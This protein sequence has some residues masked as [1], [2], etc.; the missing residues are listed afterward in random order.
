MVVIICGAMASDVAP[1]V[2]TSNCL[3]LRTVR[4]PRRHA[5]LRHVWRIGLRHGSV[6]GRY[7]IR[8]RD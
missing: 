3:L 5:E 4:P 2:G 1:E 6:L 7:G 8:P